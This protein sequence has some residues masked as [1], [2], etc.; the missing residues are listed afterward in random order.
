MEAMGGGLSCGPCY[1][2]ESVST[3]SAV[4]CVELRTPDFQCRILGSVELRRLKTRFLP[5]GN[6]I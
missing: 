6:N 4:P 2:H 3:G 1:V 5:S